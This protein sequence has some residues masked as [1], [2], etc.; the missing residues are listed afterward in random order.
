MKTMYE[1]YKDQI[2]LC[3]LA[4]VIGCIVGAIDTIFGRVLGLLTNLRE[5]FGCW[6]LIGIPFVGMFIAYMYQKYGKKCRKG[7][8]LVFEVEDGVEDKIP[9]L[10]IPFSMVGTWLTHLVGGSAG[11]EGV[12]VQIGATVSNWFSDKFSLKNAQKYFVPI[13]MSAGFGGLFQTPITACLF[14]SEVLVAG[15]IRYPAFLPSLFS[16]LAASYTSKFLGLSS[17]AM[18]VD[19][20]V[21]LTPSVII[22]CLVLGLLFGI[23]GNLFSI[24]MHKAQQLAANTFPNSY[25]KALVIGSITMISLFVLHAGRYSGAGGN[26]ITLALNGDV[27]WYDWLLKMI[28][29]ILTMCSGLMGGEVVPLFTIGATLGAVVGPLFSLPTAFV[30]MLGYSAVFCA[31]T[32][33]FF[34]AMFVGA[35]IFGF[36]YLP[37]FFI[38]CT[39][40]YIFNQNHSIYG[41]QKVLFSKQK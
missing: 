19:V 33:T 5:S 24:G 37:Y 4:I 40:A 30:A 1:E 10:L 39:V 2:L 21:E 26:L 38:V 27:Y 32:N 14:A 35:E 17:S 12:A 34:A 16:A 25:A 3:L 20:L 23:V 15:E 29:T 18:T 11:R 7:M 13:G 28:L 31:G 8:K 9:L 6:F 22:K 36:E 41:L